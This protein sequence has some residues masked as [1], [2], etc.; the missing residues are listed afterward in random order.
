VDEDRDAGSRVRKTGS[1]FAKS[2]GL[3]S[4]FAER[5]SP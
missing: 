3:R 5:L 2:V 1:D 4:D